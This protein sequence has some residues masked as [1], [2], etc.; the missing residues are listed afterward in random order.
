MRVW[1]IALAACG[2]VFF[3]NLSMNCA[4]DAAQA[5]V[6]GVM[7]ALFPMMVLGSLLPLPKKTEHSCFPWAAVAFGWMS[8]SPASAHRAQSLLNH[9]SLT[10]TQF[11]KLLAL[12]GVMSPLFFTGTLAKWLGDTR[13]AWIILLSHWAGA[14]I[15]SA[16]WPAKPCAG[17]AASETQKSLS[18]PEA[19]SQSAR[20]LLAVC[21]AMMLFS[22]AA[23][24]VRHGLG[25]LFPRWTQRNGTLLSVLWALLEIGGGAKA[26]ISAHP[27]PALLCALCSFGGLSIWLQNL[28]FVGESIRPVRLLGMRALHGAVGYAVCYFFLKIQNLLI[29]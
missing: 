14:A 6:T 25:L 22:I 17:A 3:S 15:T 1:L 26:V 4:L 28:L 13:T 10:G 2:T 18:L 16:L 24:L 19:I 5:F 27:D 8:G 21:G 11:E 23:G 12:T 29:T 7:P 20:S 9:G